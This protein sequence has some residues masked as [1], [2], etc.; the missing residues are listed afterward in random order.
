MFTETKWF[1]ASRTVLSGALTFLAT[2]FP[3][4]GIEWSETDTAAWNDWINQLVAVGVGAVGLFG[5]I[6]GRFKA[7]ND[8]RQVTLLPKGQ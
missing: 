8:Q 6:R 3:L 7:S 1:L 2:I 5:V 4:I